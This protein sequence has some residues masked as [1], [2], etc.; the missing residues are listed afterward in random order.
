MLAASASRRLAPLLRRVS[1]CQHSLRKF[2]A[3]PVP[4][5]AALSS[6]LAC[7]P[8]LIRNVAIIAHVDHGKV[9]LAFVNKHLIT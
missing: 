1:C 7:A 5:R 8:E 6:S 2:S 3:E 9:R 4:D